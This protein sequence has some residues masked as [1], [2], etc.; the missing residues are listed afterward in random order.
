MKPLL[1]F[2]LSGNVFAGDKYLAIYVICEREN[3]MVVSSTQADKDKCFNLVKY[4]KAHI[5]FNIKNA[6]QI[7]IKK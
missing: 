7:R 4:K 3:C 6:E 5:C 1:L 2:L